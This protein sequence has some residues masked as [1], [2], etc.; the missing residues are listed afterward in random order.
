MGRKQSRKSIFKTIRTIGAGG[1]G[2]AGWKPG[3]E[4]SPVVFKLREAKE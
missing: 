4:D 3:K 1:K 2:D